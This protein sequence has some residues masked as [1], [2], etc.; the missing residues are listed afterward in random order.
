MKLQV[1]LASA[2]AVALVAGAAQA[3]TQKSAGTYAEPSQPI[4]YSKLDT[5]LK[6]STHSR[7]SK[8]WAI[9]S[10]AAS[11][12]SAP[13]AAANASANAPQGAAPAGD[14]TQPS[15]GTAPADQGAAAPAP[16][17]AAPNP[18][19]TAPSA[20]PDSSAQ[21]PAAPDTSAPK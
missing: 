9:D 20:A 13:N 15:T 8:D 17:T 21:P 19:A 10:Q 18:P 1:I 4:A 16:S 11:A 3:A 14:M 2:A 12:A 5:Y 6:S 7:K